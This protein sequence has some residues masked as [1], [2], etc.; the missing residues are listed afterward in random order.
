MISISSK[1]PEMIFRKE[2][3]GY[4]TYSIGLSNKKQDGSYENGYM[5]CRFKNGVNIADKTKIVIKEGFISFYKTKNND[6]VPVLFITD[7]EI[8]E[9]FKTTNKVEEKKDIETT[10]E[11]DPYEEMGKQ[12]ELAESDLPF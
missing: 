4:T 11:P 1:Y 9:E 3:N 6:T 2:L 5:K 7:Y 8:P 12:V 10:K